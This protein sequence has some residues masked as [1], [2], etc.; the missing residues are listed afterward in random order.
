VKSFFYSSHA[1]G[2]NSIKKILP[3]IIHDCPE[4]VAK[5]S[6][7]DLYGMG[8]TYNSLN[9]EDHVWLTSESGYDPYKTLPTIFSENEINQFG[10]P[11]DDDFDEVSDGAAAML[12]YDKLQYDSRLLLISR[13]AYK[14]A[15]LR[16]CEL[17]TLSMAI[18]MEGL[19]KLD[20][21][22]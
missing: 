17:D 8:K 9:F 1:S 10:K 16:Y 6:R 11:E 5:Y 19:G 3:A 14:K 7:P 13:F 22:K 18:L 20:E 2:S 15:L 21:K 4:L 12:A